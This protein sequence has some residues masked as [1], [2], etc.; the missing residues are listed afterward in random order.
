MKKTGDSLPA[1][2]IPWPQGD[3]EHYLNNK[4]CPVPVEKLEKSTR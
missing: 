1:K 3:T 4:Q 2:H